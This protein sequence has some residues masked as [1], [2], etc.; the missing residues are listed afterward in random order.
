MNQNR[1]FSLIKLRKKG[2]IIICWSSHFTQLEQTLPKTVKTLF[3]LHLLKVH[4]FKKL[5]IF[6][7]FLDTVKPYKPKNTM[8]FLKE[9]YERL[10]LIFQS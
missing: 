1:K 9:F 7:L 5:K 6:K 10:T 2:Q 8:L 4:C 3:F